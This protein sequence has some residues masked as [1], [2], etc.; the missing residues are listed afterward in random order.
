VFIR[1]LCPQL[2]AACSRADT[3]GRM[4][5]TVGDAGNTATQALRFG[6]DLE[7]LEPAELRAEPASH[8]HSVL[9]LYDS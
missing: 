8:A 3:T 1:P 6:N 7:V 2:Q 5:T 4:N 9:A